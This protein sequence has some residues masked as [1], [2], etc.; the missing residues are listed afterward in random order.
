[1]FTRETATP[2]NKVES[3]LVV[4]LGAMGDVLHALPAVASLKHNFPAS[5]L[6]WVVDAPWAPLLESNPFIDTVVA[7]DRK[8]PRT[9]WHTRRALLQSR[10]S[11]AVDFQGL[12]KSAFVATLARP[13]RIFGF[14][15]SEVRERAAAFFYSQSVQAGLV[16]A[17]DRNL[18]LA[19]AAGA[20]SLLRQFPLPPG[21][22]EGDLPNGGFVLASPLAG[23][24]S[25]QWPLE[26]YAELARTLQKDWGLPLVVNGPPSARAV[27]Q[28]IPG[29]VV[30][31]SGI[32]GLIHATR[33]ATA[34]VGVDSGPMHLAAAL[35]KPGAAIFGP[36]DPARNGP[37]GGS[38]Q[39]LCHATAVPKLQRTDG[40]SGAYIRGTE[41]DSA[42]R[43]IT[44]AAVLESLKTQVACPA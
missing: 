22:P 40:R 13:E 42:M 3:I 41:I 16:H 20:V 7:V 29:C 14:H 30:H 15:S 24:A 4:R 9:W 6:T 39:V 2:L 17:V 28:S 12:L 43:A 23:W 34:V 37:Y 8:R 32:E 1:M 21:Q 33:R 5:R 44:P 36:T 18:A 19:K 35:N 25:K 27:L 31:V 38:L 26:H 10:Y 11:V